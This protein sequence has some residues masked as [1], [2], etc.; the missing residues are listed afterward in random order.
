VKD[1]LLEIGKPAG[2]YRYL[3][4]C[5]SEVKQTNQFQRTEKNIL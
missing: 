4:R 5:L 1:D 3:K 2:V